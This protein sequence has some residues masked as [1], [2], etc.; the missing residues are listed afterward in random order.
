MA[1][2]YFAH[3]KHQDNIDNVKKIYQQGEEAEKLQLPCFLPYKSNNKTLVKQILDEKSSLN[4]EAP[5]P[6]ITNKS[7]LRNP[8][9]I[10][11]I[12][13]H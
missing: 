11:I 1:S 12:V 6:V 9:R 5:T 2:C 8:N 7:R 4:T 3:E 10:A 13:E